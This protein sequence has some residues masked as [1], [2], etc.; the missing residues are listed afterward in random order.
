MTRTP[1]SIAATH[2]A[3]GTT[4]VVVV[5]DDGAVFALTLNSHPVLNWHALPPVPGTPAAAGSA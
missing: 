1:V 4:E 2:H 5:C 3:V